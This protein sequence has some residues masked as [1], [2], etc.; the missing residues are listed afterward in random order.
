MTDD[1]AA[2]V[3]PPSRVV[4]FNGRDVT[5][6]PMTVGQVIAISG[7][8][9]TVMPAAP[10]LAALASEIEGDAIP[11]HLLLALLKDYGDPLKHAISIAT[12]LPQS[13]IEQS[14]DFAGLFTLVAAAVA[15]NIDF[16]RVQVG[17][18]LAA[19][20]NAPE[21]KTSTDGPTPSTP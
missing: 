16:F 20:R 17:A 15:L 8:M 18:Y 6:Q 13:E 1:V 21:A 12:G 11:V 7:S 3:D 5:V 4:A 19:L 10:R 9:E 2:W 14:H